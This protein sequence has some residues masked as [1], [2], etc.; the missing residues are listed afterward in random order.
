MTWKPSPLSVRAYVAV[1]NGEVVGIGGVA[2]HGKQLVVFSDIK[3]ALKP[4][5]LT[6]WRG[7]KKVMGLVKG[8]ATALVDPDMA[9]APRFVKGLGFV[10]TGA[11]VNGQEVYHVG[12]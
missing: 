12:S 5:P 8:S 1:L 6:I 7:A 9:T 3:P 11:V 4:Y 10:P 2:F